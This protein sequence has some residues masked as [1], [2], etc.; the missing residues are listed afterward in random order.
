MASINYAKEE[1]DE[2]IKIDEI[3]FEKR[4][5][6]EIYIWLDNSRVLVY[7]LDNFPH[8]L[9]KVWSKLWSKEFIGRLK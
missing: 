2:K 3:S 5:N 1:H 4:A 9:S 7:I 6:R 8:I